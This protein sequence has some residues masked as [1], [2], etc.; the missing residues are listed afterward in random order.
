VAKLV[1]NQLF[2]AA[3]VLVQ[4][5]YVLAAASGLEPSDVH[6]ILRASSAGPYAALA[7]LLLGRAF[8]DV[9]F[10]L[11]VAAKD[12]ALAVEAAADVGAAVPVTTAALDVYRGA[13]ADGLG[14]KAFHATLEHVE[15]AA[16]RTVPA[17]VRTPRPA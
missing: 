1:N 12:L 15:R 11:D 8:D 10:R 3:G 2:L 14:G 16:G 5:A 13:I 7:P 9:V 4:E 6:E 17:L